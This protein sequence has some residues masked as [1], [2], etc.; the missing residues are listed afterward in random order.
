MQRLTTEQVDHYWEQGY[1]VARRLLPAE[2][3][4]TW[5]SRLED[6]VEGRVPPAKR[7][8][9]MRDVMVARGA[10][11]PE[12]TIK[13]IAKIQ[14]FEGDPVL[15]TYCTH[16]S[17]L[18][19]VEQLIG[20]DLQS[21][22]CMLIN[23]P[24]GVDGRHPLHQDLVYF[25]FRPA[26]AIVASWTALEPVTRANGCLVVVPGTHRGPLLDH[27]DVDWEYVNAGYW[28]AKGVDGTIERVHVECEPGDT[29]YFH[30]LL[31]HGS[32]H[33]AT[34]GFRRAIS[35]HY[36]STRCEK[37]WD[38]RELDDTRFFRTVRGRPPEPTAVPSQAPRPG[39]P[40]LKTL[41]STRR[42]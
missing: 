13:A 26:D 19:C 3:L 22:H 38:E 39:Q 23:K 4:A 33:N 24:P 1:V 10:V 29:I 15:D 16:P 18:D 21:I 25:P 36:A 12:S 7:M 35:C 9:V 11:A 17:V 41:R 34:T 5:T 6:I 20:P 28:G 40:E 42:G 14:D 31:L 27:Q 30:P 37:L 2:P 8:L 32:G